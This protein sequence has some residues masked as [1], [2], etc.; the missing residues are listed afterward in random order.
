M[1]HKKNKSEKNFN[2]LNSGRIPKIPKLNATQKKEF[3]LYFNSRSVF[4]L[5]FTI[6]VIISALI[7]YFILDYYSAPLTF[8]KIW[9]IRATVFFVPSIIVFF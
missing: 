5:R 2:S 9:V 7:P 8:K 1:Q 6:V 3:A 4:F